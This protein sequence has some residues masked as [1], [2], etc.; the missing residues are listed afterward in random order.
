VARES[1]EIDFSSIGIKKINLFSNDRTMAYETALIQ[2]YRALYSSL[3]SC[4]FSN[5]PPIIISDLIR[6]LMGIGFDLEKLKMT[7]ERIFTMKRLFNI[8]MGLT[9]KNDFLPKILLTPTKEG[10]AKG[11]APDFEKL[12]NYYYQARDWDPKTGKPNVNKL[13]ELELNDLNF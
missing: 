6:T 2:D 9:S 13:K 1:N 7:G 10:A 5:P 12:K 4:F 3:V 11:K 8:K